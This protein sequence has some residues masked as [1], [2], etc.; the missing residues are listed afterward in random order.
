MRFHASFAPLLLSALALPAHAA[1][2][3]QRCEQTAAKALRSCVTKVA[4]QVQRCYDDTGA[5]CSASDTKVTTPLALLEAK[6]LA[7]CPDGATVQGAGYGT[8]LTPAALVARLRESCVGEPAT[9]AARTFGGPQA[10]LLAAADA[11]TREC[12]LDAFKQT[13]KYLKTAFAKQDA[14]IKKA[15]AGGACNVAKTTATVD[16]A[17]TKLVAK[18][19]QAC[20]TPLLKDT[21][22]LDPTLYASRA[23]DQV[24][25]L[26]ATGHGD[27]GPLVLACGPREAVPVPPRGTWVQV[28]LPLV[29]GG[30]RCGDGSP[31]AFWLR[32]APDGSPLDHVITDMAGGGVC[33]FESDCSS[34]S[35]SLFSAVDDGQPGGGYLSTN[36]AVNP[37]SDWTMLYMPYCTQDVH[38]GGG[39]DSVFSPTLTVHRYGAVNVR[40]ALRYLRDVLWAALDADDADGWRP[41]R[42]QVLF[43]GESAGGFGVEYNYHYPLDD[44]RWAHTTALPDSGLALDNGGVGV[45]ALGSLITTEDNPYGWGTRAF[46]PPYCL[47]PGCAVGPTILAATSPRLKAVPEQQILS[48]SNQRDGTQVST[49]LFA[50]LPTW[51]N[52]LRAAYCQNQ[53]KTGLHWFLPAVNQNIHTMLRTDSRYTGL[54]AGGVTV[55]DYLAAAVTTPD[56]VVDRVDEGT[57]VTDIPGV[58]PFACLPGSPSGAFVD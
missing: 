24:E 57:F 53:G 19:E 6:V 37:F 50:D 11:A 52:A 26:T 35:P 38:I 49:T 48:F 25:C 58:Q 39:R 41:D 4:A 3:A 16:A 56:A 42:L 36:P 10:A 31:Y 17:R 47:A 46:Q 51:V 33:I 40:A 8:L 44:L 45:A 29:D 21:L 7:K 27:S 43:G 14:C 23:G 18:L 22:G 20:P 32:L 15:H 28:I 54:A 34:V 5:A 9:L 30:P 1:T 55:R 12:L 13:T 2:P